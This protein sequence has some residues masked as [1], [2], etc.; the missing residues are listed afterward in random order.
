MAGGRYF[1]VLINKYFQPAKLGVI[2]DITNKHIYYN[3]IA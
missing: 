3:Y 1:H 2:S